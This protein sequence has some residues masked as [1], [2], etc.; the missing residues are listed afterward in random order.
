MNS[1]LL[2]NREEAPF[3]ESKCFVTLAQIEDMIAKIEQ[4]HDEFIEEY[5]TMGENIKHGNVIFTKNAIADMI[6]RAEAKLSV[7]KDLRHMAYVNGGY[8]KED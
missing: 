3:D 8:R 1:V 2:P 5:N 7:L 6:L 4:R